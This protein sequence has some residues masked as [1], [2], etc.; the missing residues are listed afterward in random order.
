MK[1]VWEALRDDSLSSGRHA[2]HFAENVA[3]VE[4]NVHSVPLGTPDEVVIQKLLVLGARVGG[5]GET[6]VDKVDELGGEAVSVLVRAKLRR[7]PLHNLG[8]L[9]EDAVPLWVREPPRG[10]L[11]QG[12]S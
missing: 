10:H 12:Y 7:V 11:N 2:I 8:Q 6:G 3:D 5:L 1:S 9:L 4:C